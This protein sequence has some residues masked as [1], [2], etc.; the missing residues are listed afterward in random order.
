[1]RENTTIA[2]YESR[3]PNESNPVEDLHFHP[4]EPRTLRVGV[5]LRL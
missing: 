2:L 1:M 5:Q 4:A 3:L